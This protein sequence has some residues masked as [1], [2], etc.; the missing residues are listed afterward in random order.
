MQH[1]T[2]CDQQ[3]RDDETGELVHPDGTGTCASA[4][5][6][7]AGLPIWLTQRDDVVQCVVG[8][9]DL[10]RAGVTSVLEALHLQLQ[11]MPA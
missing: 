10:D 1:A 6:D 2:W 7:V 8:G 9:V 5:V 11:L 3:E 4:L